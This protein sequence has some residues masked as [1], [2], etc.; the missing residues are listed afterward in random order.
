MDSRHSCTSSRCLCVYPTPGRS[1]EWTVPCASPSAPLSTW[2]S[3]VPWTS[4][5]ADS[6][7]GEHLQSHC[8]QRWQE[9]VWHRGWRPASRACPSIFYPD[10]CWG[11]ERQA[12][13]RFSQRSRAA[14]LDVAVPPVKG[15]C[16]LRAQLPDYRPTPPTHRRLLRRS[17]VGPCRAAAAGCASGI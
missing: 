6:Q 2:P 11:V 17:S 1:H 4:C 3:V 8:D 9:V 12:C 14:R 13:G 16:V 15:Q 10:R 5:V 7:L